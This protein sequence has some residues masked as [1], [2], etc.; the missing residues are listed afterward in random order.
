MR[1]KDGGRV[2]ARITLKDAAP[3]LLI[4]VVALGAF[5]VGF[6]RTA[7]YA[8]L[9][10]Y[11]VRVF[12]LTAGYHRYFSHKTYRASRTF[13]FVLA[14]LGATAAQLGPLWWA[15][16]HRWHHRYADKEEDIHSPAR[17]GFWWAHVGWIVCPRYRETQFDLIKDFSRYPELR[18]IDS[19]PFVPPLVLAL[20]VY[21]AGHWLSVAKPELGTSG[22]QLLMWGFFVSTILVYHVTFSINSVM[23][24]VGTRR[25]NTGDT[26]RN[27]LILA[28][29]TLGEGWHNNHHRYAVC[30]RQGFRWCEIDLSYLV[31]RALAL[32]HIVWDIR[33]PPTALL[34]QAQSA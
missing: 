1:T 21:G 27:N 23:H 19:H 10:T 25:F 3:L 8:I 20:S 24:M 22:L 14:F 5:W 11:L 29:L 30:A 18:W 9:I 32:V 4:H 31:L 13:Q 17:H 26:S 33:E 6:S 34:A 16:H 2:N 12:A 7:G 28:I 15:A